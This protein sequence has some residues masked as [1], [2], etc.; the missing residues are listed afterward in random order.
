[1]DSGREAGKRFIITMQSSL[2]SIL[3]LMDSGREVSEMKINVWLTAVSIL[4]LMDSGR[5]VYRDKL[6]KFRNNGFQSLF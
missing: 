5:E 1:M 4:V 3:V 6:P 2:V